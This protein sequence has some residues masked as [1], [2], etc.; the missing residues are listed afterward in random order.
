M[1]LLT[2]TLLAAQASFRPIHQRCEYRLNP[3]GIDI[4]EPR[5]SWVL[6]PTS[7]SAR[8]LRQTAYRILAASSQQNLA[9][10]K[11]DLWDT[12]KVASDRSIHIVYA[13]TAL[14][15]G[16]KA[17]WK[18]QA[19][20]QDGNASAWSDMAHWSMGLTD[21][22]KASWIGKDESGF[23][24]DP[25]SPYH[26][27]KDARWVWHADGRGDVRWFRTRFDAPAGVRRAQLVMAADNRFEVHLNGERLGMGTSVRMP[28]VFEMGAFL[29]PGSNDVLV[30]ATGSKT[31]GLIA[32][33]VLD[34][35]SVSL[36]WEAAADEK[37]TFAAAKVFGDYGMEPWG[38]AGFEEE[39]V[40]P[41]RMLR[42]EF[43]ISKTVKRAVAYVSGLGLYE[44]YLNGQKVG[45]D[46][47][48]PGL[49]EYDKRVLYVTYDVSTMVRTG[50]NAIGAI[51]G[52]GRYWAPRAN[53]P[54]FMRSYGYPKLLMQLNIEY[55]DGSQT[56]VVSDHT[57][58]MTTGGPIRANNEFDGEIYDARLE[59]RSWAEA[60][61]KDSGWEPVR[62]VSPPAGR[63]VAQMAEPLRVTE[64]L[65]PVKITQPRPGVWVV[66]MGQN[67]VGWCR[68][69]VSG[70]QGVRVVMRHA[71]TLDSKG[72][73]YLDNLRSA[74]ATDEYVLK[75]EGRETW[76]PRFT[77]HG[78]RYV[79]LTGY[80]GTP[81]LDSIDGRVVHDNLAP[82]ANFQS[83]ST[84][85][86]Q[87]HRNILWGV[88]GNYRSI[89][90]DCPQR[91]ERQGWLGDRSVVSRS[92]SYLYDVAA[93]YTKWVADIADSQRPTGSVPVVSPAYWVFYNDDVT[94]PSTFLLAPNML[95]E[96]YGDTRV[97]EKNYPAMKR[98]IEYMRSYMKDDLM[99]RDTYGDWCVPPE[100]PELIHSQD[101]ARK[102]EGAL[103][104][105]AYFY[106]MLKLM[107]RYARVAGN[108]ADIDAYESLAARMKAAFHRRY[109]N[110][111]TGL[112][113][114]GTQTASILPLAFGIPPE[115]NRRT[116][117]DNLINRI[118]K[119]SNNHVGTGLVGAQWLMRTLTENGRPDVAYRIATQKTYPGWGYMID[120]G[121][122]TIWEL[123]NGDTA[124]PAMNS[125]N[126]VMQIGDL[127]VW[128]YEYLAGIRTDPEK[129]AFKHSIIK[130][131]PAG[132]LTF[133]QASHR[134]MYGDLSARWQRA[135]N[136]FEL[137][138][139][140]PPN[141]TATVHVP[142][143]AQSAIT[144][145]GKPAKPARFES[146][147][148]V[149]E[150]GS[151]SYLYVAR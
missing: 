34:G 70:R 71:E 129:P 45:Q 35:K 141:T 18:V 38:E 110:R 51:V 48:S 40:L 146:G 111:Q 102:T 89:P 30:R 64:T 69:H 53:V 86:N 15:A 100:K 147:Y 52:N 137:S 68:L 27:L 112:Y 108:T 116:L 37:G 19:W 117:F 3:E 83:S 56:L 43:N 62:T 149:F 79:E 20:D 23:Y 105:T 66:D 74:R 9:A 114:N 78:F 50:T 88:R 12:G 148:A 95:Y 82:T 130:P 138:V 72:M 90:T 97:I 61:F 65:K 28:Q 73:L 143:A 150:V 60:G 142:A 133:V 144:E 46:V 55:S 136:V 106:Q 63:L 25:A 87:I 135:N 81:A 17:F 22:W 32:S 14:A 99:P 119:E 140:I 123:W 67:M 5:L 84:L 2:A 33:A 13:G 7:A 91:D 151:G 126:H 39:R 26:S 36:A 121:A 139:T 54:V 77:Y 107:S 92:E 134:S 57:W 58:R 1:L 127:N 104:G 59:Q 94:W 75:G 49:T 4:A 118:E 145:S 8:N 29:K 113:A 98:W 16:T 24:R 103:L 120:K 47:L 76:E 132:D 85:L 109:F 41:A 21:G 44:L 131:Y 128:L 80:P 125:G 6:E 93:F 10:G 31:P 101:P 11:G 124:D 122:T 42:K 96:Q 115:Q